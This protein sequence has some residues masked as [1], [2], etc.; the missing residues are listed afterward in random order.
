LNIQSR[1][2]LPAGLL[3]L[4]LA[5]TAGYSAPASL[6]QVQ[7]VADAAG[8]STAQPPAQTFTVAQSGSYIVTLSDLALPAA[9]ASLNLAIVTP[10]SNVLTLT[11]AGTK[12]VQLAAGTYTGQALATAAAQAVGGAFGVQVSPAAGGTPVWQY[13]DTVGPPNTPSS[14]G[15]S[16]FAAKFTVGSAGSYKLNVADLAFPAALSSLQLIILNDCGT[17]P[18]C[19]SS[20][21]APTPL[22]GTAISN[23]LTL[24]AGL[25]DLFVVATPDATA[26]QGLYSVQI[27]SGSASSSSV[28]SSTVPVGQLPAP[29]AIDIPA[30]GN[31]SLQLTDLATPA[32]LSSLQAVAVEG[33]T[34]LQQYSAAGTSTFQAQPGSLQIFIAAV[35]GG[36]G[37]GAYE[38]YATEGS[39][40]LI[41]SAQ[42]VLASGAY[43]YAFSNT[44]S[45]AGSYQLSVYDYQI[46]S[47]LSQLASV[48]AQQGAALQ[49]SMG[50][51]TAQPGVLNMLVFPTPSSASD[52]GLFGVQLSSQASGSILYETTQ[53]VGALFSSQSVTFGAAG[54]YDLTATDLMF[55][56]GFSSLAV[57]ATQGNSVAGEVFGSGQLVIDAQPGT[58][59]LNVLAQVGSNAHYGLYGLQLAAAP[60][61]PTVTLS[62]SSSSVASGQTV[63]L[64]WSSSGAT[65]CIASGGWS[66]TLGTSGS[67]VS[68]ALSAATTFT[69]TC[70]G[71][72]GTAHATA[73]VSIRAPS[74][75]GGGGALNA[76][77]V[78]LLGLMCL[79]QL[80]RRRRALQRHQRA[81]FAA[82]RR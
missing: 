60:P 43:G 53:G 2:I 36:G 35:A 61:A 45:A 1:H 47:Q 19:T 82:D 38:A 4:L 20:P 8:A 29:T 3:G 72:G 71:P 70:D 7:L 79:I 6:A 64:T 21:V 16:N 26:L 78:G 52:D 39:Q 24:A 54:T 11:A 30:A 65:G 12:T 56:A 5:A 15:V 28:Y 13:S 41:D 55:P 31:I 63:T 10:T 75:G 74:G 23:T 25:Y 77:S 22:S 81:G 51:F 58:Y 40:V 37:Q 59:V 80:A 49:S 32:A 17:T 27:N 69:I 50:I 18:G 73:A 76:L 68:A 14:T 48:L 44:L 62:A 34:V 67:Q 9:L 42:P 57:I 33:G 46:P 66:G